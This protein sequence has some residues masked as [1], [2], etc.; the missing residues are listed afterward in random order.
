MPKL[1]SSKNCLRHLY[2]FEEYKEESFNGVKFHKC[3]LYIYINKHNDYISALNSISTKGLEIFCKYCY[4]ITPKNKD[5]SILD[6]IEISKISK[7]CKSESYYE[8]YK[9]GINKTFSKL[10]NLQ[11]ITTMLREVPYLPIPDNFTIYDAN[12]LDKN[13]ILDLHLYAWCLMHGVG[14]NKNIDLA[15]KYFQ[16]NFDENKYDPSG[17][18]IGKY[19]FDNKNYIH[20]CR[21][22]DNSINFKFP[23]S[24]DT[25]SECL[26]MGYGCEK[27]LY[28]SYV[29]YDRCMRENLYF[30]SKFHIDRVKG[31]YGYKIPYH[32]YLKKSYTDNNCIDSLYLYANCLK[33]GHECKKSP[34]TA[35]SLF[36]KGAELNH[37]KCIN[38]LAD[39]YRDGFGIDKDEAKA[40]EIYNKNYKE[41]NNVDALNAIGTCYEK[42]IGCRKD[43]VTAFNIYKE[44]YHVRNHYNSIY[45]LCHCYHDGIGCEKDENMVEFYSELLLS[46]CS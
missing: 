17:Y 8:Y 42:G 11:D 41:N 20:A 18:Y 35:F 28:S 39:C 46:C 33:E 10:D 4:Y 34:K 16:Q 7:I 19:H 31:K 23:I 29:T 38:A 1:R 37:Q 6:C 13:N 9:Y 44:C 26:R 21:Y 14:C 22:F 12:I 15:I 45:N 43:E 24:C 30:K 25:L 32:E 2:T 40:F 36:K 5:L 3:I 27:N